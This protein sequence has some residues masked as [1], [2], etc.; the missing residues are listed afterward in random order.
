[1]RFEVCCTRGEAEPCRDDVAM[2]MGGVR[3]AMSRFGG[4]RPKSGK[5]G[6]PKSGSKSAEST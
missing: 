4:D 6:S 2:S 1:M 3:S 5:I